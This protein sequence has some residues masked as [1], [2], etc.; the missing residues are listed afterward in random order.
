MSRTASILWRRLDRIGTETTRLEI[1]RGGASLSGTAVFA[2]AGAPAA[3]GYRI[4]VD[5]RWRTLRARVQGRVGE[6]R[7]DL[8]LEADGEA[9]WRVGGRRVPAVDGCPDLDLNF[10]PST[11]LLPIRRLALAV[12]EEAP[13]RSA[14]LRFPGFELEPLEQ[15]YGR[16]GESTWFYR[17]AEGYEA[18]LEVGRVGFVTR[19]PGLAEAV[20]AAGSARR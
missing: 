3:L 6:R 8:L 20:V 15:V 16:T 14:W 12:G 13:V 19:Y 4:E 7:I 2:E 10:S 17:T 18:T 1:R 5:R 11:N 9:R